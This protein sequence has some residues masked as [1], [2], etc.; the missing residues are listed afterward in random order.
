[1]NI[2]TRT[3]TPSQR[4][5]FDEERRKARSNRKLQQATPGPG[6][7]DLKLPVTKG[8][9]YAG[10]TAFKHVRKA[11]SM[12][13]AGGVDAG[14]YNPYE[15]YTMSARSARTHNK[16][17]SKG[18]GG[19][20]AR[21]QR[22][23]VRDFKEKKDAGPGPEAYDPQEPDGPESNIGGSAFTS[24]SKRGSHLGRVVTPGAGEYDIPPIAVTGLRV[25]GGQSSFR[26]KEDR[27]RN[28]YGNFA[29]LAATSHRG[30]GTYSQE[31]RTMDSFRKEAAKALSSPFSATAVRECKRDW[32]LPQELEA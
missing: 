13:F 30:P 5:K 4:A 6:T 24:K 20:S 1:M 10:S 31:H 22:S 7:Y 12:A 23:G 26:G 9:E 11:T 32:A 28:L 18:E 27:L 2:D 17:A 8:L 3:A 16:A 21:A 19:F 15:P 29:E 14:T 25:T